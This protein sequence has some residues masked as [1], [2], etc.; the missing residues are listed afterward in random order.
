LYSPRT[1]SLPCPF[2]WELPLTF[3]FHSKYMCS[4]VTHHFGGFIS[5]LTSTL[6]LPP[7]RPPSTSCVNSHYFFSWLMLPMATITMVHKSRVYVH[8]ITCVLELGFHIDQFAYFNSSIFPP[9]VYYTSSIL[10]P[11]VNY[12]FHTYSIYMIDKTPVW[13]AFLPSVI[14]P[15]DKL[16]RSSQHCAHS[17][18]VTCILCISL[19][20][21]CAHGSQVM[22]ICLTPQDIPHTARAYHMLLVHS[23]YALIYAL[24]FLVG[25]VIT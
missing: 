16:N 15:L 10:L 12:T 5:W 19:T 24:L 17:S 22:C 8:P 1:C 3:V 20:H 25:D 13:P 2:L 23:L 11:I 21:H 14:Q 9:V 4:H 18:Q 7:D 6:V